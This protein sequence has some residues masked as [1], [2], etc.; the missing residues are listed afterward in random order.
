[1]ANI[2]KVSLFT[3]ESVHKK[4]ESN[5]QKIR[6]QNRVFKSHVRKMKMKMKKD[7]HASPP[8]GVGAGG[9]G[10]AGVPRQLDRAL[11]VRSILTDPPPTPTRH[12]PSVRLVMTIH[13][14]GSPTQAVAG[15]GGVAQRAF[16]SQS[17]ARQITWLRDIASDSM[18]HEM[19]T[20]VSPLPPPTPTPTSTHT[21]THASYNEQARDVLA[22]KTTQVL[23]RKQRMR[24]EMTYMCLTSSQ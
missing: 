20:I 6:N 13:E 24:V 16:V 2:R 23:T 5:I 4:H 15:G 22:K 17:R 14:E 10:G 7:T 8:S 12:C 9:A 3:I 11:T 21:S 19:L 18:W 1:V